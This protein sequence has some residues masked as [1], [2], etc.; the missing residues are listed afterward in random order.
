MRF[1]QAAA[2]LF[3]LIAPSASAQTADFTPPPLGAPAVTQRADLLAE[4]TAIE[5]AL[6]AK[7]P[8]AAV[9]AFAATLLD[10]TGAAAAR[11]TLGLGSAALMGAGDFASAAQGALAATALQP[12]ALIPWADLTGVP[13]TFPPAAHNQTAATITDF[14][15]AA[16]ARVAS[17]LAAHTAAADPHPAYLTSA[18]G[19]A[20][21]ATAAQGALADTAV[22]AGALAELTDDRVAALLQPGAGVTL[23][24]N[25]PAG[26]LTVSAAAGSLADGD[27]GNVVVSGGGAAWAVT[28]AAGAFS[29][30]ALASDPASPA[31]GDLWFNSSAG[32]LKARAG[33][34][35]A[36]LT[37]Q[38]DVPFLT[39][40]SGDYL[41][42]TAGIGGNSTGT[43]AGA[44]GRIDLY[45]FMPRA[46]LSLN[47]L[48]V[49]CTTAVAAAQGKVVIYTADDL[50]RPGALLLE[51]GTLDFSTTGQ[52]TVAVSLAL[53]Q[54]RTYW[55][56]IRHS[57]TA[58]L[59]AWPITATPDLNG[60]AAISTSARKILRRTLAF[61]TAAPDPWGFSS[62]E[63][64]PGTA[65]TAIWL[66]LQ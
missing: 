13:S 20:A 18:E 41:P 27:Y 57:S 42:A 7:W 40:V 29:L 30:G 15:A 2:L 24:Y 43:L 5:A 16:D 3:W 9:S 52:K 34:R 44:A 22:Q 10:D 35:T 25:D 1:T 49:N 31:E 46:D 56:G 21:F 53:R 26:S 14:A 55:I 47:Q 8:A 51:T 19:A 4:L 39:P 23:S 48:L 59:S 61:G 63:I 60:G 36:L 62:A 32:D 17:G 45:P 65:A 66:R 38:A 11:A 64:S 54:G 58:T 50:G 37:A 33:G 28:G 6:A 12:G